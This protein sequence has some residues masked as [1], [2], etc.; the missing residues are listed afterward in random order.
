MKRQASALFDVLNPIFQSDTEAKASLYRVEPYV[1]CAD[2]YSE[3][4]IH[5]DGVGGLGIQEDLP[6][7]YTVRS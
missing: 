5:L 2:I 3:T 1:I 4:T 7:F 6:G